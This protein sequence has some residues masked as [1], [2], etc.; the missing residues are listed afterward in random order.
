MH[1][2]LGIALGAVVG[3]FASAPGT[4]HAAWPS[5]APIEVVVGFAPGGTTDVM[6]RV[7]APFIA[8]HLDAKASLVVVNRPGASGELAVSQVMRAKPDGY[9]I[10]I[11]NL[12]GYFFVPM[13]RNASYTTRD[14]TLVARVVSDPTVMVARKDAKAQDLPGVLAALKAAPSSISAGHN[15]LGT[16]GHLAMARLERAAGVSFNSIPYNGS[17]QQKTALAGSHLDIAFLAASEV[18]DPDAEATPVRLLAQFTREKVKRLASVP[19]TFD[20][21]L[22]VDMT[23][24]RGF[25][26]PNGL[27]PAVL[28]RLQQ[29]I[30][31][32][33]KDPEY[34]KA[35]RND[36]PFLSYLPG[37]EWTRQIEQDRKAYEEIAKTLPKQ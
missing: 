8:K 19:S 28:T 25:A 1:K 21:G 4:A 37:A 3:W 12:P 10:G 30:E 24:E 14:L 27:P 17:A 2:V 18:P 5:D 35:A 15:G 36:A 6:V 13:M 31:A 32:A 23:A 7:L 20:L 16:N 29:V 26:A 9:T 33:M 34:I 11:V 22:S